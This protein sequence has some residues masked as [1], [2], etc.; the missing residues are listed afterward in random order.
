MPRFKTC[1]WCG[2]RMVLIVTRFGA[3]WECTKNKDHRL[4][5]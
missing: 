1:P 2:A 3:I 4:Q 5:A